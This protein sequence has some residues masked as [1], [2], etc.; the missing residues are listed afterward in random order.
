[1]LII[2]GIAA[3]IILIMTLGIFSN[4]HVQKISQGSD[5]AKISQLT[6]PA[7]LM[8]NSIPQ[9]KGRFP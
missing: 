2:T 7:G 1:M 4:N 6:V 9:S 8:Q 5:A 3:L